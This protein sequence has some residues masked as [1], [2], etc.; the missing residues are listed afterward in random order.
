MAAARLCALAAVAA[1]V[2]SK[3][4]ARQIQHLKEVR[5]VERSN[6]RAEKS[7]KKTMYHAIPSEWGAAGVRCHRPLSTSDDFVVALASDAADPVPIFA[8]INSTVSNTRRR[9]LDVVAFVG[10][11]CELGLRSLV[12]EHLTY[13]DSDLPP[14]KRRPE[15]RVSVCGGLDDQLRQRPAMRALA[16]LRNSTRVKRKELLSAFNFAAFYLPHVLPARR[17]LYLDTDVIVRGDVHELAKMALDGAPAAAVEDCSQHLNKYIDFPLA[18]AYRA[19]A[20]RRVR[21]RTFLAARGESNRAPLEL[22]LLV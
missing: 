17:I 9:A 19:A 16:M 7:S 1:A 22:R 21:G 10:P 14:S 6:M 12:K 20:A 8:A 13:D 2:S 4:K 3:K 15:L 5:A 18:D 11:A